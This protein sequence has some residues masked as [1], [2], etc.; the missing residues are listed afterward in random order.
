VNYRFIFKKSENGQH[1]A[2]I[3]HANKKVLLTTETYK[4]KQDVSNMLVKLVAGIAM[5]SYSKAK[6]I[7]SIYSVD[8]EP[9]EPKSVKLP[10]KRKQM[11]RSMMMW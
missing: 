10:R 6:D 7:V 9:S 5:L 3:R 4:R 11:P 1:Y 8:D 2:V